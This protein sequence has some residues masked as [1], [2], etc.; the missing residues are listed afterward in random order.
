MLSKQCHKVCA[1]SAAIGFGMV[2]SATAHGLAREPLIQGPSLAGISQWTK[3]SDILIEAVPLS[4]PVQPL[5][6]ARIPDGMRGLHGVIVEQPG[7]D[8]EFKL[9]DQT[10]V[11]FRDGSYT[12]DLHT[13]FNQG[14]D[15]SRK[16]HP[17]LWGN[18][19]KRAGKLEL[20]SQQSDDYIVAHGQ[21]SAFPADSDQRLRGCFDRFVT[22]AVVNSGTGKT[23]AA[24][25]TWCFWRDGRFTHRSDDYADDTG[26][27]GQQTGPEL[28]GRYRIDGYAVRFVY[29]DG[30]E[31]Q[32]SFS[33]LSADQT[34]FGLNGSHY[35][36]A[37]RIGATTFRTE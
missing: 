24:A 18:L 30:V 4:I 11:T 5:S 29:D 36:P 3:K 25:T 13:V 32:G 12:S 2:I 6:A 14:V 7:D 21:W 27:A 33:F 34:Q 19:R 35:Q 23:V 16:Q 22:D 31:V 9:A 26:L 20:T 37:G 1:S 17:A 10:L 8:Q 15:V 28:R